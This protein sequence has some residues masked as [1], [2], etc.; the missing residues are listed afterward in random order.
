MLKVLYPLKKNIANAL[1]VILLSNFSFNI[2]NV[3]ESFK[4]CRNDKRN[5]VFAVPEGCLGIGESVHLI[6]MPNKMVSNAW[7]S[8]RLIILISVCTGFFNFFI[9]C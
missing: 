8:P 9:L 2:A 4:C 5:I 6:L 3:Y 1:A 7:I